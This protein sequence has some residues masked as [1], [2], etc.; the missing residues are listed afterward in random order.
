MKHDNLYIGS[1][2]IVAA[3]DPKNGSE[4]WRTKL[5]G[6]V[7]GST[8]YSDV[9]VLEDG[10]VV[11]AGCNGHLFGLDAASGKQLWSNGLSGLGHNDI[12]LSIAGK[13]MQT[14]GKPQ[15]SG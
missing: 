2:G 14:V 1:N 13:S 15:D 7:F 6:G 5:S 8:R 11:F 3:I 10:G 9:N 4:L 12:T